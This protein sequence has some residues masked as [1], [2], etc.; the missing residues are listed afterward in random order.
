MRPA[1]RLLCISLLIS[2]IGVGADPGLIASDGSS[3]LLSFDS[4]T[5]PAASCDFDGASDLV[6]RVLSEWAGYNISLLVGACPDVCNL[7]YGSG[8]PDISGIGVSRRQ[9][10]PVTETTKEML[11]LSDTKAMSSYVIQG[12]FSLVF[13]P[14]LGVLS[15][16]AGSDPDSDSYFVLPAKLWVSELFVPVAKSI[17]QTNIIIAFSVLFATLIR[18]RQFCP[19]AERIFLQHLITYEFL[20]AVMCAFSYL[21][22]HDSSKMK[23]TALG[24]YIIGTFVMFRIAQDWT[25]LRTDHYVPA[26]EAITK[27]CVQQHDWPVPDINLV[28][29]PNPKSD[30]F[31]VLTILLLSTIPLGICLG[32]FLSIMRGNDRSLVVNAIVAVLDSAAGVGRRFYDGPYKSA[33]RKLRFGPMRLATILLTAAFTVISLV[34]L[35]T[36]LWAL[37]AQRENLRTASGSAYQDNDCTYSYSSAA[38]H[39][40]VPFLTA[41]ACYRG[42]R[43]DH[44]A[45]HVDSHR[46]RRPLCRHRCASALLIPTHPEVAK[47]KTLQQER[48]ATTAKKAYG[49]RTIRS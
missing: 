42:F 49:S 17:H 24:F 12:I 31:S 2:A 1:S 11:I 5:L 20:T 15:L 34:M 8:N 18:V 43:T 38:Y 32:T 26:F 21:A 48:S 46:T 30:R 28:T 7:V 23:Q 44:R 10:P 19:M 27:Y 36:K 37:Q 13:G 41:G 25:D 39:F 3:T 47:A 16:Y 33:C 45:P 22:M 6:E 4:S 9:N 14:A 35:W 40:F 29:L